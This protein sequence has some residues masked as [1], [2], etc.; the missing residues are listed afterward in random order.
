[1]RIIKKKY[2][3]NQCLYVIK[4]WC[5]FTKLLYN[6]YTE[7]SFV[8]KVTIKLFKTLAIHALSAI[9]RSAAPRVLYLI[10]HSCSCFK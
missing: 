7:N 4:H 1:M 3:F 10:K 5:I 2:V 6:I 9:K 8:N